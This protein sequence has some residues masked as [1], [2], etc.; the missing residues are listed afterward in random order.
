MAM[1]ISV[2]RYTVDDLERFPDDGNR[3]E[4]LEGML[5]V[6]PVPRAVHQVVAAR[7]QSWLAAALGAGVGA[8]RTS[9]DRAPSRFPPAPSSSPI[10]S[11]TH[12]RSVRWWTG[13]R[14]PSTGSPSRC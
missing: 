14:S 10:S 6:M 4:L 11:S 8:R 5:L 7:I 3:Y 1:A 13:P 2:P 9:S 12:R